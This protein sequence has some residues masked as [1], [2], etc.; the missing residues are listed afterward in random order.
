[1]SEILL[2]I[3]D[4]W[5]EVEGR[6]ILKGISLKIPVGETHV[7]FGKNGSGK[8]SLLMTIM[9][10]SNYKVKHGQIIFKGEDITKELKK[11]LA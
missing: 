11:E 2:E 5:V 7:I 9:G 8:T 3:K 6:L 10:F 4:L 1:M